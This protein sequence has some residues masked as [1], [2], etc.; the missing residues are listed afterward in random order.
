[1][2]SRREQIQ[3]ALEAAYSA[4]LRLRV[5]ELEWQAKW[6]AAPN[7]FVAWQE[8]IADREVH[9]EAY[10]PWLEAKAKV[11]QLKGTK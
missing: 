9:R 3:V 2:A 11:E 5:Q 4:E 1:M 8:Y 7:P 10:R 6:D